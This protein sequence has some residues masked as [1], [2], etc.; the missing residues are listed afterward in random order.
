MAKSP[1]FVMSIV[2]VLPFA[3]SAFQA[4]GN[5]FHLYRQASFHKSR[6]LLYSILDLVGLFGA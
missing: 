1:F 5:S 6:H 4:L 2:I 3:L